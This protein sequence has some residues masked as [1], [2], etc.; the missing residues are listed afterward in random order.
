M[1][2][3][4]KKAKFNYILHEK[5]EAGISLNGAE[6]KAVKRGSVD[7][8][9]S[10]GKI[11]NGEA[12]LIN[13]NIAVG[14]ASTRSRKL[15][16][17]KKQ[18]ESINAKIKAKKLTFVPIK[19]YTRGRLIKVEIALAKTKR[20]FEKRDSIRRKDIERDI[21]RELRSKKH[22]HFQDKRI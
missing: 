5:Y 17:H 20:N 12:F 22:D 1:K 11:I 10:Y 18:I 15:L 4:N 6:V 7:L 19:M 16:L 13:A 2:V 21:E 14:G 9:R 3:F 8:S